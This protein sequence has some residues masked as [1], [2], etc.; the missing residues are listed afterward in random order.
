M[1]ADSEMANEKRG[2]V[3]EAVVVLA[4]ES[5]IA[6]RIIAGPVH[7]NQKPA[8]MRIKPDITVGGTIDSPRFVLLLSGI[9]SDQDSA[10]KMWRNFAEIF[11][12][13]VLLATPAICYQIFLQFNVQTGIRTLCKEMSDGLFVVAEQSY[14][15]TINEWIEANWKHAPQLR[16]DALDWARGIFESGQLKRALGKLAADIAALI[17][18]KTENP[19]L[20]AIWKRERQL[21]G[22]RTAVIGQ[23][24]FSIRRG[25]GKLAA[26]SDRSLAFKIIKSPSKEI[27]PA[28]FG[29]LSLVQK[30]VYGTV[31]HDSEVKSAVRTLGKETVDWLLDN[32]VDSS[33]QL[34]A[35]QLQNP[36]FFEAV[37]LLLPDLLKTSQSTTE[38]FH[39]LVESHA[40][41]GA[42]LKKNLQLNVPKH[43]LLPGFVARALVECAKAQMQR[44][45][46]FGR[47][48]WL[49]EFREQ[50]E[51]VS[52][53]RGLVVG[54]R[55]L[56][57]TPSWRS[58]TTVHYGYRDWV[59]GDARSNFKLSDFEVLRVAEVLAS[60]LASVRENAD[61]QVFDRAIQ[62]W[63][64]DVIETELLTY[65]N[66]LPLEALICRAVERRGLPIAL[67]RYC[68]AC[69]RA[70]AAD[71]MGIKVATRTGSTTVYRVGM[72]IIKSQSAHDSHTN[73]KRKELCG[74]AVALRYQ[75]ES[76]KKKYAPRDDIAR[77]LLVLDGTWSQ[78]DLSSL[79]LA[80]WDEIFYPDDM[81]R[82]VK[83]IV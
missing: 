21:V 25:V 70:R 27:V 36:K 76:N 38:L 51:S 32:A 69:M 22:S 55:T 19:E 47:K 68:Q 5:L 72:T 20:D 63:V 50:E 53:K 74:R 59:F 42:F 77:L 14:G 37:R 48:A 73:D 29:A 71:R 78:E 80:G 12:A 4:I 23:R 49:R 34:I 64:E 24:N 56:G 43:G 39:I 67:E 54:A 15:L 57:L 33:M 16:S 2:T 65:N 17:A 61:A 28:E 13:K 9:D 6:D 10:R 40:D 62:Y 26:L 41:P 46:S 82:L 35:N 3:Y 58:A 44:R 11:E 83:A 52:R 1:T 8:A 30:R 18:C 60:G 79:K 75:W 81:D 45:Q 31:I 66:F 7:W